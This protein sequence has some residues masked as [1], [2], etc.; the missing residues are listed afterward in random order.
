MN[1]GILITMAS[2]VSAIIALPMLCMG[3]LQGSLNMAGYKPVEATLLDARTATFWHQD[4][5]ITCRVLTE[6]DGGCYN[7]QHGC[8]AQIAYNYPLGNILTLLFLPSSGYCRTL[9]VGYNLAVAGIVF[10]GLSALLAL[11]A[12]TWMVYRCP[13]PQET[14]EGSEPSSMPLSA[15]FENV[16]I[17]VDTSGV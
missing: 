2:I 4:T 17:H 12:M 5:L 13:C 7:N 9:Q 15:S 6:F 10:A 16:H 8:S 1:V 14:P 11:I 3:Y